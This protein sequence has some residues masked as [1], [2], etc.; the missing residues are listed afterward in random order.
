MI[1]MSTEIE[2]GDLVV[3]KS[4]G[5]TMTIG[6]AGTGMNM[7]LVECHWFHETDYLHPSDMV[8]VPRRWGDPR[9]HV[10]PASALK[11]V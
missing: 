6:K 5:P 4:G 2:A 7:D 11:K 1:D 9:T 8:E 3:L 10:F